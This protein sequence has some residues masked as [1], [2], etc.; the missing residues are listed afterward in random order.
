V[1]GAVQSDR[2]GYPDCRA[3]YVEA[4]NRLVEAGTR[5]ETRVEVEAPLIAMG[6]GEIVR[7]GARIGAPFQMSW[8][9]YL[10]EDLAC[11]RCESCRTRLEGFRSAGITDPV[12][13]RPGR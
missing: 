1:L 13:Y 9:C 7:L 3:E 10:T 11:G 2:A 12:P 5:P 8:S 6:K 4:L